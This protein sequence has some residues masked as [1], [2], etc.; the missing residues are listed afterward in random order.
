MSIHNKNIIV[1]NLL[2][3]YYSF[4]PKGADKTIIFLHGWGVDSTYWFKSVDKLVLKKYS[5]YLLDLPGFGKSQLPKKIF[6]V[7]DYKNIV[8]KFINK[9]GLKKIS[10]IGHSFGG[11]ITIRTASDNPDFLEKIVLVDTAGIATASKLKK[12]LEILA[13][14]TSPIFRIGFMQPLRKRFYFLIG[15]EYLENNELSEIFSKVVSENLINLVVKIKKP[16]LILWGKNDIVTPLYYGNLL[17]KLI[18]KSKLSIFTNSG[19]FPFID[20]PS[21]FVEEL[22]KFL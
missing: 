14:F 21:R 12:V 19:H 9:L 8:V 17:H 1:D 3:N 22:D 5:I 20:E 15:S 7:N 11:R 18:P 16:T 13:K 2:L 10:L 4:N 6:S